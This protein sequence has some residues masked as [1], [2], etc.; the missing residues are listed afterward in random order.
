MNEA[1]IAE[2][3]RQNIKGP[4]DDPVVGDGT[5]PT[6]TPAEPQDR[7]YTADLGDATDMYKL[8]DFYQ[9]ENVYRTPEIEKKITAIYRW[10]SEVAQSTDYLPVAKVILQTQQGMPKGFSEQSLLDKM[11]TFVQIQSR[12]NS[13]KGEQDILYAT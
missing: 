6:A 2:Q 3:L 5:P 4:Q 9:I 13:L 12:I 8:Y 10:A 11:Y 1:Q 7:G